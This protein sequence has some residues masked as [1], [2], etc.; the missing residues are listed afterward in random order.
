MALKAAQVSEV[1]AVE[2]GLPV[3][4][5]CNAKLRRTIT[6][7][8]WQAWP[9]TRYQRATQV[10]QPL[11]QTAPS[12][13]GPARLS[14]ACYAHDRVLAR[15]FFWQPGQS[16]P[17]IRDANILNFYDSFHLPLPC[18]HIVQS[19]PI[20]STWWCVSFKIFVSLASNW[21][22]HISC[23]KYKGNPPH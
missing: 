3:V 1:I 5:V 21:N 7:L 16:W 11:H 15:N 10:F 20:L 13:A 19:W 4:P 6:P 17:R 14:V 12:W 8:T 2:G 23:M 9:S 18:T 22:L